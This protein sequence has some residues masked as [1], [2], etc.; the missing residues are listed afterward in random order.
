[1]R[2][3]NKCQPKAA[4]IRTLAENALLHLQ[5]LERGIYEQLVRHV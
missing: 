1:M 3:L 2:L 4:H 5:L